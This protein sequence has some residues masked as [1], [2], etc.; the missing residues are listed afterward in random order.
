MKT[1]SAFQSTLVDSRKKLSNIPMTEYGIEFKV[2]STSREQ[3]FDPRLK[4]IL[5]LKFFCAQD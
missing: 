5:V 1:I 4:W 3:I 2:G